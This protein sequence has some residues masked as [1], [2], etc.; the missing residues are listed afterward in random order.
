MSGLLGEG[1]KLFLTVFEVYA[2]VVRDMIE[3]AKQLSI[4]D[5]LIGVEI[6][7]LS[8]STIGSSTD[9]AQAMKVVQDHQFKSTNDDRK[10]WVIYNLDV[11]QT[12]LDNQ[13]VESR[14]KI[15]STCALEYAAVDQTKLVLAHGTVCLFSI[16]Y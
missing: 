7:G 12:K 2:D 3:P 5:S 8:K 9:I 6:N 16:Y 13:I 4:T 11:I 1:R 10:C 15:I 14:L